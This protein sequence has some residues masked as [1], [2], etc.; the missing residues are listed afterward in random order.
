MDAA[1]CI[2]KDCDKPRFLE[3]Y[4]CAEH[5]VVY[6]DA[7]YTESMLVNVTPATYPDI[8]LY[9]EAAC[10]N[11]GQLDDGEFESPVAEPAEPWTETRAKTF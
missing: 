7:R 6:A 8:S 4:V 9:P 1:T 2:A 5:F 10:C 3:Y 11:D